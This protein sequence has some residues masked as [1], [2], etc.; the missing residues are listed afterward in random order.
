MTKATLKLNEVF[1]LYMSSWDFEWNNPWAEEPADNIATSYYVM[2]ADHKG[3]QW[4]HNWSL[5]SNE[6]GHHEAQE[7][8]EKMVERME[9]HLNAG[10]EL[11]LAHW[12][13]TE[14]MYGSEA[15]QRYEREEIAPYAE[16][17]YRGNI[18]YE[19]LPDSVQG[20]F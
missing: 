4:T 16:A 19:D 8:V 17:L 10:G 6:V 1:Q 7:R 2:V 12:R 9:K 3:N 14:P 11:D 15:W 20:Y 18:H 13:E 5:R